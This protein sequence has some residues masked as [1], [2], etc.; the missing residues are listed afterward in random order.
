MGYFPPTS[1]FPSTVSQLPNSAPDYYLL[2]LLLLLIAAAAQWNCFYPPPYHEDSTWMA[3]CSH[4][5]CATLGRD[6]WE[7]R[8]ISHRRRRSPETWLMHQVLCLFTLGW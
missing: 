6:T 3:L 7:S 5:P 4:T 8:A 1:E 2:L